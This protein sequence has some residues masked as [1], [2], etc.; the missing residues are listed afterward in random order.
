[1][2]LF[3]SILAIIAAYLL[4]SISFAIVVSKMLGI[5]DPRTFGSGNPGATNV[6]R[7]G[8]KKAAAL[9]LLFDL[10]K[11]YIPVLLALWLTPRLGWSV[12]IPPAVALA[13]FIGHLLPIFF[14]F[15]GGKGVATAAG[16]L[17]AA[18]PLMTGAVLLTWLIIAVLTRYSSLAALV[19]AIAAP[20]YY[21]LLSW[22]HTNPP[23]LIAI[24]IMSALLIFRHKQNI[25]NLIAGNESKI[26]SKKKI[27]PADQDN[28]VSSHHEDTDR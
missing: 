16:V 23:M 8:S 12:Y 26:G 18:S 17:L 25:K 1:M 3:T 10:L 4:G 19:A 24:T 15:K 14:Q 9:T 6:L 2:S 22:G 20:V 5:Q 7:S 27:T 28:D 13:A 11:G 21:Q